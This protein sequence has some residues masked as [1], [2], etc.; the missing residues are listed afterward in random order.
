VLGIVP[1]RTLQAIA[2]LYERRK[3]GHFDALDVAQKLN[4]VGEITNVPYC[5]MR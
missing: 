4:I 2:A 3:T 1:V 5:I